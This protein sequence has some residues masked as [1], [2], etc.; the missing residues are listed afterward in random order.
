MPFEYKISAKA[1]Q[2]FKDYTAGKTPALTFV[3]SF[4]GKEESVIEMVM[5]PLTSISKSNFGYFIKVC[6]DQNTLEELQRYDSLG[7]RIV[8]NGFNY[9]NLTFDHDKL[10]LK[11]KVVDD[12]F[13]AIDFVTPADY[14]RIS[15]EGINLKV[16]FNL[17]V[18]INFGEGKSGSFMKIISI[19]KA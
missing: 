16:K 5:T 14:D 11:L 18:W 7:Q 8:P 15:L 19:I 1:A 12:I 2:A 4:D 13:T 17:G 9:K 10:Y 3:N 6:L